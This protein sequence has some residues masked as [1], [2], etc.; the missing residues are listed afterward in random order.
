MGKY[1]AM[2]GTTLVLLAAAAM[3]LWHI[4]SLPAGLHYDEAFHALQAQSD[5]KSVV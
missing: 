1:R 2:W 5:R 4:T 3:H